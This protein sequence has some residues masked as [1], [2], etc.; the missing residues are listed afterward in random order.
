VLIDVTA[1][2]DPVL[3]VAALL[4]GMQRQPGRKERA[5]M[6]PLSRLSLCGLLALAPWGSGQA[7]AAVQAIRADLLVDSIGVN[8]HLNYGDSAYGQYAQLV[9]PSLQYLGVRHIRDGLA[10]DDFLLGPYRDLRRHGIGVTGIVPYQVESMPELIENI[11]GQRDVL[12]AVEGPNETDIFTQFSYRGQKFPQGTR[13]FMQEFYAAVKRDPLLARL[14]VLQTTLAFPGAAAGKTD[15]AGLLGDLSASADFGNSHNYF[16][17]GEAPGQVIQEDHLPL[18]TKITPDK[19]MVSTE[20]G[21]QM[22]LGDGYRGTWND[23]LAA[24]F[25]E[26]I[27]GRYLLRYV[28]EQ[29]RLGYRRSFLYE[30]LDSDQPQWGLFRADGTP[31]P[32]ATGIRNMVKILNEARWDVSGQRWVRPE[33]VPGKLEYALGRRPATLHSLLFQ[34]SGGTF[35]L[36]LWNDALNW[37]IGAGKPVYTRPVPLELQLGQGAWQVRTFLPLQS[38]APTVIFRSRQVQLSVPDHP[39]IVEIRPEE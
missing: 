37:N 38:A 9:R 31:R 30:L 1:L 34:K 12:E 22:G 26:D 4:T 3:S 32:A 5:A 10:D 36:L 8:T 18:N 16:S 20:G 14:P 35:Y 23:D 25:S 28:L 27:H 39:V 11:R 7:A 17:F 19:P 21:Y 33:F 13:A 6:T 15:R 2:F 29:Y 24:P